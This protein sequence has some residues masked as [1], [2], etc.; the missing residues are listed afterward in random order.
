[1]ASRSN[2]LITDE[3]SR[4]VKGPANDGAVLISSSARQ[5]KRSPT[6]DALA[7]SEVGPASTVIL[8][9]FQVDRRFICNPGSRVEEGRGRFIRY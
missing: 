4:E 3:V 7:G 8:N 2:S 1:M 6:T 5:P 9:T